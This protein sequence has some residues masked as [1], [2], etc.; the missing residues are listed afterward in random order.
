M[1]APPALDWECNV[2]LYPATSHEQSSALDAQLSR[3]AAGSY[4]TPGQVFE[5]I[6]Y[7]LASWLT[8][9]LLANLLL[10]KPGA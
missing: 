1:L 9:A 2:K 10:A 4:P 5:E 8:L 3:H 6:G 7:H